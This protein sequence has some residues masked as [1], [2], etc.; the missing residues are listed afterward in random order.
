MLHIMSMVYYI[1]RWAKKQQ[2]SKTEG[3]NTSNKTQSTGLHNGQ[4]ENLISYI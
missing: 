2:F 4:T 1:F 3:Q